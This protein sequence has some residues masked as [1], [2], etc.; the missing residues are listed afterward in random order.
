[1]TFYVELYDGVSQ[2]IL[3]RAI[4]T[5]SDIDEGWMIPRDYMSNRN[6]L[7]NTVSYW[8]KKLADGIT[9]AK[10]VSPVLV[11]TTEK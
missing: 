6:A 4:D 10:T 1:M 3:A 8:A 7:N 5:E 11:E 2:Q 9:R